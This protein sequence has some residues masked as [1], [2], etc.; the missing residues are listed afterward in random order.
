MKV[1]LWKKD[2]DVTVAKTFVYKSVKCNDITFTV[3]LLV[4]SSYINDCNF[5]VL[6]TNKLVRYLALYHTC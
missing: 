5:C 3:I 1:K 2:G 6:Q 4:R